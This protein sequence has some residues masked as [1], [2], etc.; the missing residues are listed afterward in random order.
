M[1]LNFARVDMNCQLNY[2]VN[3]FKFFMQLQMKIAAFVSNIE[4]FY[5]KYV[6]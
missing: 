4:A 1:N 3:N 5:I 6:L 2:Y